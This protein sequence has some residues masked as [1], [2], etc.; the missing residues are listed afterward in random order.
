MPESLVD[1]GFSASALGV[2]ATRWSLIQ[3]TERSVTKYRNTSRSAASRNTRPD[4]PRHLAAAA[5]GTGGDDPLDPGAPQPL[6]RCERRLDAARHVAQ[7][8]GQL[9]RVLQRHRRPLPRAGRRRVG[10]V[11]HQHQPPPVPDRHVAEVVGAVPGQLELA[12][13]HQLR[14]RPAS[15]ASMADQPL[16]PLL[17]GR[18]GPL[19]GADGRARHVGEPDH[20]TLGRPVGAEE[21]PRP[22][23]HPPR[24]V[25]ELLGQRRAAGDA[26]EVGESH[27]A[28]GR[29]GGVHELPHGRA[30]A[31]R[32]HEQVAADPGAVGQLR[33]DPFRRLVH[34]DDPWRRAAPRSRR[35]RPPRTA[36]GP[37]PVASGSAPSSRRAG[38]R[39]G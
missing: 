26:A 11:A 28:R 1:K 22:E 33:L 13:T 38:A 20:V 5:P 37:G 10:G 16:L 35:P 31:V 19:L 8:P 32:R 3:A 36:A 29:G 4:P 21:G 7:A 34:G 6:V 25:R 14:G 39:P 9:D 18:G 23:D 27:V 15:S 17:G 30:D 12:R 2:Q 24:A